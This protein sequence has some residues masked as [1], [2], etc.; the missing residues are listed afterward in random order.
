VL[1]Y[2]A[3]LRDGVLTVTLEGGDPIAVQA[4]LAEKFPQLSVRAVPGVIPPSAQKRMVQT[5]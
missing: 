4:L 3:A 5:L 2:E 1:D